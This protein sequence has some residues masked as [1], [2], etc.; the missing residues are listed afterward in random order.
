VVGEIDRSPICEFVR[1]TLG[2]AEDARPA[3]PAPELMTDGGAID[4][5][6]LMDANKVVISANKLDVM[7]HKIVFIVVAFTLSD[8][9]TT[10]SSECDVAASV[11]GERSNMTTFRTSMRGYCSSIASRADVTN[12]WM[13]LASWCSCPSAIPT[14]I[15]GSRKS[16]NGA[17]DSSETD[18][19]DIM[20]S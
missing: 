16:S 10:I 18:G 12:A 3:L 20:K 14:I 4:G 15:S 7:S 9:G 8:G 6:A 5:S 2:D 19:I 1:L 17:R 13:L 11:G